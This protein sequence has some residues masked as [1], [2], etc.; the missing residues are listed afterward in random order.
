MGPGVPLLG[1]GRDTGP[2]VL[3]PLPGGV[4]LLRPAT[5]FPSVPRAPSAGWPGAAVFSLGSRLL[6]PCPSVQWALLLFPSGAGAR[7]GV[8]PFT[9]TLPKNFI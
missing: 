5:P 4:S 2:E 1:E 9:D 7:P 6:S 8:P 3:C